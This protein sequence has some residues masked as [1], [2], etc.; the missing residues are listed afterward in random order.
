MQQNALNCI[1]KAKLPTTQRTVKLIEKATNQGRQGQK[2]REKLGQFQL[3][4]EG[5]EHSLSPGNLLCFKKVHHP[6]QCGSVGWAASCRLR[7]AWVVG[8]VLCP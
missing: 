5:K 2:S 8:S 3:K 1:E 4:E 6:G 7:D